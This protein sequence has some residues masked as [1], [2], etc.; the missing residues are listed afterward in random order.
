MQPTPGRTLT[1]TKCFNLQAAPQGGPAVMKVQDMHNPRV[2]SVIVSILT[3]LVFAAPAQAQNFTEGTFYA[4]VKGWT[5]M[6]NDLGCSAFTDTVDVIFNTPPAGG[7]QLVFPYNIP[8][9][10]TEPTGIVDVDKFSFEGTYY[11]DG[12]WYYGEFPAEM[13]KTVGAGQHLHAEIGEMIWDA[14]LTGATAALLKVQECW[15]MLT[16]WSP[17][18][19]SRAGTF[20][21][22]DDPMGK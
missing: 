20:A 15:T 5:V 11:G 13:R 7:W 6:Q 16:G 17:E 8:E 10:P 22:S 2:S 1:I 3:A 4:T 12:T 21:F 9:G 19:S 18:T 14:E